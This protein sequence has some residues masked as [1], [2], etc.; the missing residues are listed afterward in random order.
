MLKSNPSRKSQSE[1][2]PLEVQGR[3]SVLGAS[4][5]VD[6]FPYAF[7]TSLTEVPQRGSLSVGIARS[8]WCLAWVVSWQA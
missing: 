5:V 6:R 8:F 2:H 4:I 1:T 3:R 7:K